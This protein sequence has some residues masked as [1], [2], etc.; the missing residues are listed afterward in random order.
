MLLYAAQLYQNLR[1][2]EKAKEH[3]QACIAICDE[4][5]I[6][7]ERAWVEC[8]Y[9]WAIAELGDTDHGLSLARK[10]LDTQVSIGAQVAR[11]YSQAVRAEAL[12]HAGRTEEGLEAVEDGLTVSKQNG[13][14]FYDADLWRLKGELLNVQDNTLE[15]ESCFHKAVEIGRQQSAK[16]LQLSA[17]TSLARLWQKQGKRE[18]A[19]RV[20]GETYTWFTEGFDTP[21][22]KDAASLLQ[23]LS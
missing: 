2:P 21:D 15:A 10:A 17:S 9:G 8:W 1:Q 5:A 16:S 22:L 11:G 4:H 14:P 3:G 12:W 7:L 20:L 13:E 6:Q 18:K 19:R 23:E